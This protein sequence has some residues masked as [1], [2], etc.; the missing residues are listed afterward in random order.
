MLTT[1]RTCIKRIRRK[2]MAVVEASGRQW[3]V[4]ER[5]SPPVDL[6]YLREL[7]LFALVLTATHGSCRFLT[8]L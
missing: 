6:A 5:Y 2:K 8:L 1:L 3:N 4:T 7:A